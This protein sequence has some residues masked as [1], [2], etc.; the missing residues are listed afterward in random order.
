MLMV[1]ALSSRVGVMRFFPILVVRQIG[2][3]ARL[4]SRGLS[5]ETIRV[6]RLGSLE[7][8]LM[9]GR[10]AGGRGFNVEVVGDHSRTAVQV[11]LPPGRA[12][13]HLRVRVLHAHHSAI[14]VREKLVVASSSVVQIVRRCCRHLRTVPTTRIHHAALHSHDGTRMKRQDLRIRGALEVL[15]FA[16]PHEVSLPTISP[17]HFCPAYIACLRVVSFRMATPAQHFIDASM[18]CSEGRITTSTEEQPSAVSTST[19]F[20]LRLLFSQPISPRALLHHTQKNMKL[21]P[22]A[23]QFG[24]R[25]SKRSQADA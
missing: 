19:I 5:F 9:I 14:V 25:L 2:A 23:L 4:P 18:P 22:C 20:G 11:R 12:V 21:L 1:V 13:R 10:A 24:A 3:H 8:D 7:E 16:L 15:L 6:H 17:K